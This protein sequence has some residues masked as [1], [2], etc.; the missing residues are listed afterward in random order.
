MGL[1]TFGGGGRLEQKIPEVESLGPQEVSRPDLLCPSPTP[2]PT[3]QARTMGAC[4]LTPGY[5]GQGQAPAG[6]SPAV[7]VSGPSLDLPSSSRAAL[8]PQR[9]AQGNFNHPQPRTK[10]LP[11][12]RLGDWGGLSPQ[13]SFGGSGQ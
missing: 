2:P 5:R 7:P 13:C 6:S 12:L 10:A 9:P 8:P 4:A 11:G 1:G 3:T